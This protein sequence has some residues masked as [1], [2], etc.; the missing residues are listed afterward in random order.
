MRLNRIELSHPQKADDHRAKYFSTHIERNP[1]SP[2]NVHQALL[3]LRMSDGGL[4]RT[5][6]FQLFCL[7]YARA[8]TTTDYQR[9]TVDMALMAKYDHVPF[10]ITD[11][12]HSEMYPLFVRVNPH[13]E[14]RLLT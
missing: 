4:K 1:M 5:T 13:P 2:S 10:Y 12:I 11:F 14:Q 3:W 8:H 6:M 7:A 9:I